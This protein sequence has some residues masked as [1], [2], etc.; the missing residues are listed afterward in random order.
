MIRFEPP[1]RRSRWTAW[2]R[3]F[4]PHKLDEPNWPRLY[5]EISRSTAGMLTNPRMRAD[6]EEMLDQREGQL[7]EEEARARQKRGK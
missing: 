1:R 4:F 5:L 3:S 7:Q 2:L 6:L